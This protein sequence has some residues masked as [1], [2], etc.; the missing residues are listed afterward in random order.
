MG[1]WPSSRPSAPRRPDPRL[2]ESRRGRRSHCVARGAGASAAQGLHAATTN[3]VTA[4]VVNHA[5]DTAVNYYWIIWSARSN[6]DRGIVRPSAL[7][8][9]EQFPD[10]K[11]DRRRQ[12][13]EQ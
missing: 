5:T 7:Y 12:K 11:T 13:K 8:S 1:G 4:S 3:R 6:T 9:S 10:Q 2:G